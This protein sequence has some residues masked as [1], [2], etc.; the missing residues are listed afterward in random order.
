M[1]CYHCQ[2]QFKHYYDRK[3]LEMLEKLN[4]GMLLLLQTLSCL[5]QARQKDFVNLA[6]VFPGVSDDASAHLERLSFMDGTPSCRPNSI[7]ANPS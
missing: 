4:Y 6:R 2:T 1:H 5:T 3:M 7:K